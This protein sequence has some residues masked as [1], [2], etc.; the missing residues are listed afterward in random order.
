MKCPRCTCPASIPFPNGNLCPECFLDVLINRIRRDTKLQNPFK[1]NER[2]LV[3]GKLTEW[4]L[5]KAVEFPLKIMVTTKKYDKIKDL[6]R[7]DKIAI[8]WTADD[9][10]ELFF[11]EITSKKPGFNENKKIIKL[12]KSIL[13][14]EL[15]QA[16]KI[17][18]IKFKIKKRNKELEKIHK[19]YTHSI[20]GL[21]KS[22]EGFKRTLK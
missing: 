5:K 14:K 18:K 2:V 22:A 7:Y 12:F 17:L 3:F 15:E 11:N 10:A 16:S 19:K 9:E 1:I 6:S 4:F 21:R 13:D 8:P 20:F